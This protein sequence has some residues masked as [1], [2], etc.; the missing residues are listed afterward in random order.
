MINGCAGVRGGF[1]LHLTENLEGN[2]YCQVNNAH[3]VEESAGRLLDYMIF[4]G[5]G[6][7]ISGGLEYW[8]GCPYLGLKYT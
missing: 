2:E 4:L 7:N 3:V 1:V 8:T 5:S 6:A